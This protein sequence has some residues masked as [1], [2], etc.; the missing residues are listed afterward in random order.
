MLNR[1]EK[2]FKKRFTM[3]IQRRIY[4]AQLAL[5]RN[6]REIRMLVVREVVFVAL[7]N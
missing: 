6:G 5:L 3:T 1:S 4:L 2:R 7:E